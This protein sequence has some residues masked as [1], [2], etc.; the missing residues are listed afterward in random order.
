MD[1]HIKDFFY[2]FFDGF[3]PGVAKLHDFPGVG[4][5]HMVVLP[6]EIRFFVLRQVLS[7][8]VFSH[9]AAFQ[10]Q[11]YGV[12]ER[13]PANAVILVLHFYVERFYVEML[14]IIVHF[15]ENG[16]AL[17]GFTEPIVF[18]E[19]GKDF[20]YGFLIFFTGHACYKN[21]PCKGKIK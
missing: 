1:I 21:I 6:V 13:G 14:L 3:Y 18:H 7:E 10:Q 8:L 20:F 4:Q 11:F 9:Q 2:A 19:F 16:I 15:I 5:D 12:V 17:L